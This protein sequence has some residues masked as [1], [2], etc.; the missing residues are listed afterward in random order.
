M[1][2]RIPTAVFS[3]G[4]TGGHLYPALALAEA[5][6]RERPDVRVVF[7]GARRGLEARVLPDRGEE[8]RLIPIR[9]L[10]R[11]GGIRVNLGVPWALL[12]SVAGTLRWFRD[13][14]P[15]LVVVTGGYAGAPAGL[16]AALMRIPLVLQEQ[17]AYPGITTRLLARWAREIH[18]AY[19]EAAEFIPKN[20]RGRVRVSGNPVRPPERRGRDMAR[21]AMSLDPSR[22]TVLVVGGSQGSAALNRAVTEMVRSAEADPGFQL[23]WATGPSHLE[24]VEAAL[25]GAPPWVHIVGYI[26]DMA[27]AL[28]AADL[29]V[30]R[31]GAM[32]TSE[33]LAWGLPSILVP[34]PTAAADHQVRNAEALEAAGCAVHVPESRISGRV[35]T[36]TIGALL[37]DTDRWDAMAAAARDRALP[38]ASREIAHQFLGFLGHGREVTS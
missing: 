22:R 25:G 37:R 13:L 28:E 6:R 14:H 18:V 4:G 26:V 21:R 27:A 23:L 20:A 7:L 24:T 3:G 31:A 5:L 35:L 10:A 1:H 2:D 38:H 29:A 16:A 32:A 15:E 19:P 33:F 17:N 8:H 11:G 34:L 36:E 9:G 12:R 30:S